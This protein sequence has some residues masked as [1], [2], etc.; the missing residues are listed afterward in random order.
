MVPITLAGFKVYNLHFH[1]IRRIHYFV[2]R[3][4]HDYGVS[5]SNMRE[6]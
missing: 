6:F 5:G 4:K 1:T 2:A 3:K